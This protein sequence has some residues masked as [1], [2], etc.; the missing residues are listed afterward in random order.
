LRRL[1]LT[2]VVGHST[3]SLAR[4]FLQGAGSRDRPK[5]LIAI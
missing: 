4:Y 2:A 1:M 3:K 5:Q